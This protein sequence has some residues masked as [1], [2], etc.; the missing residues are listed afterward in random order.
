M[1]QRE[2]RPVRI[3]NRKRGTV[4]KGPLYRNRYSGPFGARKIIRPSEANAGKKRFYKISFFSVL[5]R[6][7]PDGD[8]GLP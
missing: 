3:N 4:K 8:T 2:L 7:Y 5:P 1:A 6:K